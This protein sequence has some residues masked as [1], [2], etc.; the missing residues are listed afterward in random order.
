[1]NFLLA[2]TLFTGMDLYFLKDT[3]DLLVRV[4]PDSQVRQ[5]KLF[6][7]FSGYNWDSL[8]VKGKDKFFD[9]VITPPE[10]LDIVGFYFA[11]NN[12]KI[13][14]NGG[15]LYLFEVKKS[16]K[17]IMTF[18]LQDLEKILEQANKKIISDQYIDEALTLL[19]YVKSTLAFVPI[20]K[21]APSELER[22]TLQ[23]ETDSL[24]KQ[25]NR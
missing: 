8:M 6:Y 23:I 25:L 1:M 3:T 2:V 21:N 16:P 24:I 19:D 11:Y 17:M 12:G 4:L 14:D 7:S 15:A 9:V 10:I 13:D 18:S 5:I 20:I 22:N